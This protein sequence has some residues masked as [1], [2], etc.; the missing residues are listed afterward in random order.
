[1]CSYNSCLNINE[2][3]WSRYKAKVK[4]KKVKMNAKNYFTS[5]Y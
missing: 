5:V 4:R 1:M 3:Y 2:M